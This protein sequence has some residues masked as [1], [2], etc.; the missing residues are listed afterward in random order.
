MATAGRNLHLKGRH[1]PKYPWV[2]HWCSVLSE[3]PASSGQGGPGPRTVLSFY[4]QYPS[5]HTQ[6]P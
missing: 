4:P 6:G 3:V 5:Q 1:A 2:I